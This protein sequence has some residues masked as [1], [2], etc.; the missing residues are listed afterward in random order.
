MDNDTLAI[1]GRWTELNLSCLMKKFV[2]N[3]W[4]HSC[5]SYELHTAHSLVWSNSDHDQNA[6]YG[7]CVRLTICDNVGIAYTPNF[8]EVD[9]V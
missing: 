8:S 5:S 3:I 4:P 7:H 6:L 9:E 1:S 2:E